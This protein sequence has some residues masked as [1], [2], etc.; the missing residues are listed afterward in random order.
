MR[1]IDTNKRKIINDPVHGFISVRYEIIFDLME[2]SYFQRLRRICQLGLTSL[3][4]PGAVHTRFHHA[5]GAMHLMSMAIDVIR[6][7]GHEITDKEAEAANIAILLHDIGHG[8]Y[9]HTLENNIVTAY[10]HE[11]LSLMY[12][13]SLNEEFGG[14]LDLAIDIFTDSYHKKFL[15]QLVSGQLDMD[16]LDYLRRDSFFTGVSEGVIGSERIIKMLNVVNDKLVVDAKGIYSIEKFLIARRLMYWQ[17]YLHK[18]VL[19]AEKLLENTLQRAKDLIRDG[20][21][22]NASDALLWFLTYD[23]TRNEDVLDRFNKLDDSD[24]MSSVKAWVNHPD[25]I[26]S[27][28]A[29]RLMN[30]R[31]FRIELQKNPFDKS[32]IDILQKKISSHFGISDDE[33]SYYLFSGETSN[34]AYSR[35]DEKIN[36]LKHGVLSDLTEAS[37]MFNQSALSHNVI[38]YYLCYPKEINIK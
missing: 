6:G 26:L 21:E 7:K 11:T 3:V 2:H 31:L 4:Y 8:P 1:K 15:H 17:V 16:R 9:S 22:I 34:A 37:D 12:M 29:G 25:K 23:N 20:H 35:M 32:Y 18:T 10:D 36:I 30:R 27:D 19:S 28:L 24:I 38:K 5:I 14:R 13:H 33:A